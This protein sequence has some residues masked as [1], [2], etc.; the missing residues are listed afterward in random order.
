MTT[1]EAIISQIHSEAQKADELRAHATD[2]LVSAVR[3]GHA[4]GL[5]Q[6]Q[7]A[8]AVGRSQPEVSRLLRFRGTTPLGQRLQRRRPQVLEILRQAGI[9]N[10]RVFGSVARGEDHEDSDIDLLVDLPKGFGLFDL[11]AVEQ[12]L[13]GILGVSVDIVPARALFR[14]PDS[15]ATSEAV[16]L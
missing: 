10:P 3:T 2:M 4:A 15:H 1:T 14:L 8:H 7:I 12:E 6:R 9:T 13:S 16:P 5:T 11:S